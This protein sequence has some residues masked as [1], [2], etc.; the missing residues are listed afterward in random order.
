MSSATYTV[1]T[2]VFEGPLE[3]L[4]TL[5]EKRKLFVSDIALS[6]VADDFI[7]Y[8][9]SHPEMPVEESS[10]FVLVAS[11]LVLIK[12]KSLLPNMKLTSEEEA[13]IDDLSHRLELYN[14]FKSLSL[15]IQSLFGHNPIFASRQ[16][17]PNIRVFAPSDDMSVTHIHEAIW[18]VIGNLPKI[19][20]DPEI[21]VKRVISLE[22]VM[23]NLRKRIEHALSI[24]FKEFTGTGAEK[25]NII[26]G[27][28]AL[29]ELVKQGDISAE[30]NDEFADIRIASH[31]THTP[32]YL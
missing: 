18:S 32:T 10:Q 26:V 21:S 8:V 11:T 13:S 3:L 27:F 19:K 30:Q 22:E 15:S 16:K 14:K 29:L 2:P 28:L 9:K 7:A 17:I 20:K 5:I 4:L 23:G 31:K 25:S 12:S 24:S 6:E 1:K